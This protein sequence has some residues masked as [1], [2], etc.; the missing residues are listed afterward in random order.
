MMMMMMMVMMVMM[1]MMMMMM[2]QQQQH[3]HHPPA[4][5][6][7]QHSISEGVCEPRAH[8]LLK[9]VFG[10][11][12][13]AVCGLWFVVC[14]LWFAV[15]DLCLCVYGLWFVVCHHL[16]PEPELGQP[17]ALVEAGGPRPDK[18]SGWVGDWL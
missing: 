6:L 10:D 17:V 11:V 12:C 5:Y 9:R 4:L 15:C 1:M 16:H 7:V 13:F 14:G 18:R 8:Q 3:H 2:M